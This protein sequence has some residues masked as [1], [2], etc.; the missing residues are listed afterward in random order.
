MILCSDGLS[1]YK[2]SCSSLPPLQD[3]AHCWIL[4][5]RGYKHEQLA[6]QEGASVVHCFLMILNLAIDMDHR[7]PN[8]VFACEGGTPQLPPTLTH[9]GRLLIGVLPI[10]LL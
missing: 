7:S 10:T 4:L 2:S 9:A 8:R 1:Q 5:V 6:H 3:S